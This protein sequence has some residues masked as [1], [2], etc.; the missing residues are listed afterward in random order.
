MLRRIS[1]GKIGCNAFR[2]PGHAL[3]NWSGPALFVIVLATSSAASAFENVDSWEKVRAGGKLCL[4]DHE[5]YG[6]SPPWVNKKG[7]VASAR[8]EWENFTTWEYGKKWGQFRYAA[9]K[10]MTCRKGIEEMDLWCYRSSMPAL[11]R[12]FQ[13]AQCA[14]DVQA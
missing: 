2:R 13:F 9:G 8:R 10:R 7:A 12:C 1:A 14:V 4:R 5:H 3:R 11:I 6:E